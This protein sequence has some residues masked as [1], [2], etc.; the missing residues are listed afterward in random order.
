MNGGIETLSRL[1]TAKL[2]DF[3]LAPEQPKWKQVK[4]FRT[5]KNSC[6]N[7]QENPRLANI[8]ANKVSEEVD[9]LIRERNV[10]TIRLSLD[11][12][13]NLGEKLNKAGLLTW[14]QKIKFEKARRY[15]GTIDLTITPG[16]GDYIPRVESLK[17]TPNE[18]LVAQ[19]STNAYP[20][21]SSEIYLASSSV[22]SIRYKKF[23]P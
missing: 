3:F 8:M 5:W 11:N 14:F 9:K 18:D 10:I 4:F 22:R 17:V 7:I 16:T 13:Q 1:K 19:F 2:P 15:F 12:N 6:K 21:Q 20:C 23:I